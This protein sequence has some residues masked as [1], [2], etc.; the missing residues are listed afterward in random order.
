MLAVGPGSQQPRSPSP[1]SPLPAAWTGASMHRFPVNMT[2]ASTSKSYTSSENSCSISA[3]KVGQIRPKTPLLNI[4]HEAGASGE[5]FTLKEVMHYLGQ[6]IMLKQLYDQQQQHIVH[7]GND[8]LGKVFG[9]QSF[10]VKDP[11]HLYEMLSRNLRTTNFQDAVQ[12]RTLVKDTKCLPMR[13]DRLKCPALGEL[14]DEETTAWNIPT[15][16]HLKRKNSESEES[17]TDDRTEHQAKNSISD[18]WDAAGLPWWFIKSLRTNYG[19]RKSGSTDIHSNQD[20]D[21]AIVSD[22]T[23]DLW[24]LNE[25]ASDQINVEIKLETIEPKEKYVCEGQKGEEGRNTDCKE[26]I[27]VTIYEA[28]DDLP[29]SGDAT[30]TEISEVVENS[31]DI[32]DSWKCTKCGKCNPSQKQ[33]CLRCWALRKGWHL[34]PKFVHSTSD[35]FIAGF[36]ET[37]HEAIDVPDCRKSISEPLIQNSQLKCKDKGKHAQRGTSESLERLLQPS[38]SSISLSEDLE[39]VGQEAKTQC[40]ESL[41]FQR[42]RLGPC[43]VCGVR[44]RTGNIIHGKTG[45][46]VAC[47]ACAKMLHKRKLPCPVCA[48]PINTVIRT[49]IG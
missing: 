39:S 26:V 7:C 11:S 46:L 47:Y 23:D 33:Y 12:T 48:Q 27:E 38:T 1:L 25:P 29:S 43:L 28:D 4:L 18:L 19:S 31:R 15:T 44:P 21:T 9:V 35:P 20:I 24:F 10:S 13:E 2:T 34:D 37:E 8:V 3:E 45:H 30:D 36:E 6:Y 41:H 32:K 42:N 22:S 17:V 14:C 16:S 5:H 49:F 40:E